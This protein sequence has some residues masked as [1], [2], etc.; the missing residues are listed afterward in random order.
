MR[1]VPVIV[2]TA[3][4]AYLVGAV[5]HGTTSPTTTSTV[6]HTPEAPAL[7]PPIL[8]E[9]FTPLSCQRSTTLGMEGCAEHQVLYLDVLINQQRRAIF[10]T[11]APGTA[12]RD[13]VAAE[14]SWQR[15][16]R[17]ACVSVADEY[18]AGSFTPVA[19]ADCLVTLNRAHLTSLR[20][21][22]SPPSEG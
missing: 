4:L 21:L 18:G 13:F 8:R 19:F 17:L 16:R 5:S 10:R 11:L 3:L 6:R 15:S 14:T 2:L 7:V 1:R 20:A 9:T 22:Y 12:R